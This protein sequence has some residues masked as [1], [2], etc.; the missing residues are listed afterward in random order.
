ML[1]LKKK[2]TQEI[3]EVAV[4]TILVQNTNWKN[5][6]IAIS[7]LFK[8]NINS[9][10]DVLRTDVVQLEEL[11]RPAGFY[12]QKGRSLISLSRALSSYSSSKDGIPSRRELID[13]KGVGKET[14]DSLLVYCFYSPLP[15]VGSYTRRFFARVFGE[16]K[17]LQAKY[18]VI[19]ELMM[20]SLPCDYFI[21]GKFH[22]LIVCHSQQVCNKINPKCEKCQLK[23]H[24]NYG[25][26]HKKRP[27]LIN[28]QNTIV[29]SKKAK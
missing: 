3:F 2:S 26:F 15:I 27:E 24:C 4:G 13:I 1:W 19:Q 12:K 10:E 6:D 18:E 7:N 20:K 5:V 25:K 21:L 17:Y 9:F 16:I 28:I 11:I 14:A 23:S 29:N 22:A 8:E